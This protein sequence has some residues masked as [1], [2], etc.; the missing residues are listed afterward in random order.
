MQVFVIC[1]PHLRWAGYGAR[2]REMIKATNIFVGKHEDMRTGGR[3]RRRLKNFKIDLTEM[4]QEILRNQV[5]GCRL[6]DPSFDLQ[7]HEQ[8]QILL[9]NFKL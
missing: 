6:N 4:V 9:M 3:T 8:Y 7:L 2:M 5:Q 1:T